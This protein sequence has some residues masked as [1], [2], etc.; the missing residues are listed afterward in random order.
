MRVS[1]RWPA[2]FLGLALLYLWPLTLQP[3]AIPFHPRLPYSDLLISHLPNAQYAHASLT[4]FGQWPLWNAQIMAGQP[5]A[6]DPLAGVWYPPNWILFIWPVPIAFNFLFVLHVAWAGYGVFR[7]LQAEGLGAGVALWGGVIFMGTPK[8]MAHLGAGHVSLL[9]AVAWTPWCVLVARHLAHGGGWRAGALAGLCL[10]LTF[11]ADVRWAFYA[12][13]LGACVVLR[14]LIAR[15]IAQPRGRLISALFS[16]GI[17]LVMVSAVLA[18]PLVEF[19]YRSSRSALTL[20]EAATLSLPPL[21][22]LGLVI[23]PL[24]APH[25]YMTY[26]GVAPLLVALLGTRRQWF[27]SGVTL[28]S[29]LF[30]LGTSISPSL[31]SLL[32]TTL[33]GLSILRVPPR[34]WFLVVL[35]VSVLAAHGAHSLAEIVPARWRRWLPPPQLLLPTLIIFTLLDLLRVNASVLVARPVPEL[36][37]ATRWQASQPGLFRVYSPS[38]SLPQPDGLQHVDGINPLH[39]AAFSRFMAQASGVPVNG[40]SVTVPPFPVDEKHPDLA[41]IN[42]NA[43]LDPAQLG[44]LNTRYIAAEFPLT[45][46]A[47]TLVQ[48]FG[49]THLY[50]NQLARPRIWVEQGTAE[51]RLWSPNRIE[52]HVNGAGQVVLSEIMYPG[53]QASANGQPIALETAEGLLRSIHLESGEYDLV[54]EFCPLTV[55]LGVGLTVFGLV[56]LGVFWRWGA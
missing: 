48:V 17:I 24:G 35:G 56:L 54:F 33:P 52:A 44:L 21:Y 37:P 11:L 47:L 15:D 53:W 41:T 19:L 55:Y 50:E 2:I 28:F 23:P 8:L 31:F 1:F 30:A 25:E 36:T 13:G 49:S 14:A 9:F 16:F 3:N 20:A 51:I 45:H 32:F 42:Q 34:I 27:W 18:V 12:G 26:V 43:P 46:T 38:Y 29:I 5:F 7:L 10:A 22:L 39:L 4:Q 40:Y 6:A